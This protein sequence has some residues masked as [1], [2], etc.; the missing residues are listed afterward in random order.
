VIKTQNLT[1]TYQ[2]REGVI[3]A[4]DDVTM[5]LAP[6]EF[7]AVQ[8]PSGSGKTTLLL[9]LGGLLRPDK[10]QVL[11]LEQNPY[12]LNSESRAH[13]RARNIGFVFQQFH[14]IPYLN[15]LENIMAPSVAAPQSG[16]ESRAISLV[17][18]FGLADRM[19]H[20]PAE[21]SS[22]E[23]QRTA[24]ARALL[25]SP[26]ILLADE[27]TGNID[28][29]NATVI[30]G[31]LAGFAEKGGTVILVTHDPLAAEYAPRT[32]TMNRGRLTRE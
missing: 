27:P 5:D 6:G 13:L 22:G 26:K 21:L 17:E 12:I 4:L 16:A 19:Q 10:G 20:V 23:R 11:I 25:N 7:L 18:H 29:D 8:G 30:L 24:L 2:G 15:V 14:L 31:H 9:T 1:K 3:Q 32:L 28:P